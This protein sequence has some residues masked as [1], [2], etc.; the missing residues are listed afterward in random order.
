MLLIILLDQVKKQTQV[1]SGLGSVLSKNKNY[2]NEK[3][4]LCATF[5]FQDGVW[6][7][8]YGVE[9]AIL[10]RKKH[11]IGIVSKEVQYHNSFR[12]EPSDKAKAN[13]AI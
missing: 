4:K 9:D 13:Y 2:S 1:S 12:T 11:T 3:L 10:L 6:T 8:V 5:S 7:Y